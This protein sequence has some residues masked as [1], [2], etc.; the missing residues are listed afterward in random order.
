MIR[1]LSGLVGLWIGKGTANFPTIE[2]TEYFEELE[3]KFIGDDESILFEQRTWY[4][5][6]DEKGNPLHWESG[7]IISYPDDSFELLNSQNS[8]RVEVMRNNIIEIEETKLHLSFESK[9]FANDERMVRTM[10]EFFVDEKTL[11]FKMKMATQKTPEFQLHLE[12]WL[13]MVSS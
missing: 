12:S 8:K 11:H 3:F 4:D 5:M 6:N 13:S 7:F 9:Y 10:R 2:K 1:K